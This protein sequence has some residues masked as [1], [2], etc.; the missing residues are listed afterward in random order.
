MPVNI[1]SIPA[2]GGLGRARNGGIRRLLGLVIALMPLPALGIA[3]AIALAPAAAS[4]R[5]LLLSDLP[6]DVRALPAAQA[7]LPQPAFRQRGVASWYGASQA[8][9]RMADGARFNPRALTAAHASL[10]L[11]TRL[12]VVRPS[13][14]ASVVVTITD[15]IGT[16]RRVIDLSR[17]AA[18]RLGMVRRGLARVELVSLGTIPPLPAQRVPAGWETSSSRP[19]HHVLVHR[20][21]HHVVR[22]APP[23][24]VFARHEIR[25]PVPHPA[26]RHVAARLHPAHRPALMQVATLLPGR[27]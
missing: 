23:H 5:P 24:R 2:Q 11:G 12:R 3:A 17:A 20:V 25:R 21:A 16:A 6:P 9:R 10:P 14:G 27:R 26:V 22:H 4:A 15:R 13:T 1:K 7:N 19:V 18:A 8:G